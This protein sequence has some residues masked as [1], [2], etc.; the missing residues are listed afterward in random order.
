MEKIKEFKA[1]F[2]RMVKEEITE[3]LKKIETE[4][5]TEDTYTKLRLLKYDIEKLNAIDFIDR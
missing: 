2:E 3:V 1:Q 5:F 4:G